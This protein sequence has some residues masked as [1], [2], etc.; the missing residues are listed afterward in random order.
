[1]CKP[2]PH[3]IVKEYKNMDIYFTKDSDLFGFFEAICVVPDTD[4]PLLPLKFEGK[5]IYPYGR[6]TGVYFTE[7]MRALLDYGYEF[8]L[9]RGYEF[10]KV[11]LFSDYVK[12]FYKIKS[13]SSGSTKFIAK[14]HLNQL[15]GYFGRK[16]ET[17]ETVNIYNKDIEKYLMSRVIKSF[18]KISED[19]SCL[20]MYTNMNSD[21]LIRLNNYFET[22]F[23][24]RFNNV[25]SNVAIASA[26][27]AYS[28]IHMI[29]F[30]IDPNTFYTDTDSFFTSKPLNSDLVSSTELGLMKDELNGKFIDKAYF[31][32]IK[33]YGYI[34]RDEDNNLVSK[35]TFAG[36]PKNILTFKEIEIIHNNGVINKIVPTRFY[37]S[38]K[39]LSISIKEGLNI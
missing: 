5:T 34:Y 23:V 12:Y 29:P 24:N 20:L 11:D 21:I 33:Q 15:Y 27:T 4:R 38:F 8:K 25:K 22:N 10:S 37:K 32:G 6:W 1:M 28:R 30:K 2:M 31:L 16:L 26:V 14:M 7:E 9:L 39:D 13:I 18:I 3:E 35:S 36:V 17:L 19:K